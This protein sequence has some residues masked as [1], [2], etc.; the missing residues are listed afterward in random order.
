MS[1]QQADELLI[2][3]RQIAADLACLRRKLERQADAA[4]MPF[5]FSK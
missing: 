1:E 2:L 3:L 4:T 5:E